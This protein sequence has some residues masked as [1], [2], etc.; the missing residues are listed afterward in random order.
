[1]QKY[2]CVIIVGPT[3]SGKT[4]LSVELA[5]L[6]NTEIISAD[7]QQFIRGLDI[8]TAKITTNEMC[9]IKHHMIDVIDVGQEYTVSEYREECLKLISNLKSQGKI[10][11]I[12]GGTGLYVNSLIYNYSFGN[13]DKNQEIRDYYFDLYNKYDAQYVHN[14]LAELDPKSASEIH[15][16]NV[17]RVIRAIEIAKL[18]S[19]KKSEQVLEKNTEINPLIIGLNPSRQT[20]YDNINKRADMMIEQ[21]LKNETD[22]L[23]KQGYYTTNKITL[24][25]SYSEWDKYYV[26]KMPIKCVVEQ[27]KLDT[28]HYAKRQMTWFKKLEN[29]V[30]FNPETTP[31]SE[32]LNSTMQLLK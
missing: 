31:I 21:G 25:I 14:I 8:G 3:A 26:Q 28:K 2:D 13:T 23:F 11:I 20:L 32:I 12:A 7:S 6:L 10:P 16:N 27:I 4:K 5:K 17:K 22:K 19:T 9:G 18:S 30:W 24:P 29:V 1:M 15:P